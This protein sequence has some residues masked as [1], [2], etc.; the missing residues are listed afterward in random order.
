MQVVKETD[1]SQ[2]SISFNLSLPI[3]TQPMQK[4][5]VILIINLTILLIS[6]CDFKDHDIPSKNCKYVGQTWVIES[7]NGP[8][9]SKLTYDSDIDLESPGF[10]REMNSLFSTFS[11]DTSKLEMQA[12]EQ[13]NF[14]YQYDKNGFLTQTKASTLFDYRS[15]EFSYGNSGTLRNA[16][17]ETVET[18]NFQY[19]SNLL[20]TTSKQTVTTI[21]SSNKSPIVTN[22]SSIK[23]YTY[24]T[25]GTALVANEVYDDGQIVTTDFVDGKISSSQRHGADGTIISFTKY[26][27]QGRTILDKFQDSEI[28]ITYDQKDN[29]ENVKTFSKGKLQ[30]EQNYEHDNQPNPE[31]LIPIYFKGIPIPMRDLYQSG[32]NN[33]LVRIKFTNYDLNYISD[34]IASYIYNPNGLPQSSLL[35]RVTGSSSGST[36]SK[37]TTFKYKDCQ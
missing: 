34:E 13:K 33:N 24:N 32:D 36:D 19:E 26:N 27:K 22:V 2:I 11:G 9:I 8:Y 20:R 21:T 35:K 4:F 5:A 7:K 17:M 6:S 16:K 15:Q 12:S 10:P 28:L 23:S 37:I 1:L 3:I 30:F 29:L 14:S 25:D 18:T 31:I